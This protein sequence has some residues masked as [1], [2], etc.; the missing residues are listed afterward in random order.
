MPLHSSP[1]PSQDLEIFGPGTEFIAIRA[2]DS[3]DR[4]WIAREPKCS[5]LAQNNIA[6]CGLM[7]ARPPYKIVRSYQSGTFM[8]ACLEGEGVVLA[9]GKWKTIAAGEACLLPPFT[10]NA[11]KCEPET[12]WNFAWVRYAETHD[13]RPIVTALSPVT[14]PFPGEALR[15][16]VGG[17]H[18]ECRATNNLAA[19]H[20]WAELI[21][22]YVLQFAQPHSSDERLWRVWEAVEKDL[23]HSWN[24]DEL[25]AIG[26]L[27]SEHLRRIC[28]AELGRSPMQHLTH[29]RLQKARHLLSVTD[30]K[31][32]V[33]ARQVGYESATTFSNTFLKWIGC[34]PSRFRE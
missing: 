15:A 31:V 20:H 24:L 18:A 22:H 26:C 27:S 5:L 14:G 12:P 2:D 1:R 19:L 13:T 16:A 28:R 10:L 25:A 6:H 11:L 7:R 4:E 23:S 9:D 17:L 34:R 30:D 32:E 21:H 3:D 33:I 29:L 8:L